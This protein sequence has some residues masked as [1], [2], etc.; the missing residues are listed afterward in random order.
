MP[1][2]EGV[3]QPLLDLDI[4]PSEDEPF[5]KEVLKW[6]TTRLCPGG[7]PKPLCKRLAAIICGLVASEKATMGK[8][9]TAIE[10]LAITEAK[11]ESIARRLQRTL[12]DARLDPSLLPLIFRPLLP[13]LLRS[14]LGAHQA[15]MAAASFHHRRFIGVGIVL[16][17]SSKEE[18]VHLLVAGIPIGGV[19]VPLAVRTWEQNVPLPSGEYW[20]QVMGLLLEMQAMLPPQL[21]DHILLTAD[22]F[23]GVPK[24]IDILMALGWNWL[25]RVQGQTRILMPD[26]TCR[27][28]KELVPQPGTYWS[29]GFDVPETQAP[30]PSPKVFKGAGWR[31]SQVVA[32]W[33]EGQ[34]EPWLL[35]TSLPGRRDRVAEYAQR[36]SIERLFLSW[37]SHGWDI[38]A[39]GIRDWQRL[40]RLLTAVALATLWRLSMGLCAAVNSLADWSAGVGK[41]SHQFRLPAFSHPRIWPDKYS[42]LTWGE[43][44]AKRESL[45][46]RT[47]ALCWHLPFWEGRTWADVC[48]HVYLTA[49]RQ[50]LVS[51]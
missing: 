45:K 13:E 21:R 2:V 16:D 10:T 38:E 4:V 24:M 11:D 32:V 5:Y 27:P 43:K 23:Y 18:E 8:I 17:E 15:N 49:H 26:G 1:Q 46:T 25:L 36:W 40:G 42:L 28:L 48:H 51:P 37:K 14:A 50:F 6:V 9:T 22:R 47:P 7:F 29:S 39:S 3:G 41:K 44:A 35:L 30:P 31:G 33:Q 19:V 20:T 34:D 12:R